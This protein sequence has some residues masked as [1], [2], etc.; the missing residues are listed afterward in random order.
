MYLRSEWNPQTRQFEGTG[1]GLSIVREIVALHK[2]TI[3]VESKQNRGTEFR[4]RI[5]LDLSSAEDQ[6][7]PGKL[8]VQNSPSHE[9][10]PR[11]S[12]GPSFSEVS[13]EKRNREMVLVVE[14]N[15]DMREYVG[16]CLSVNYN[17]LFAS[18]RT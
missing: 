16:E 18:H 14:D 13:P 1:I 12:P 7:V 2:G 6:P 8:S 5:P 17:V 4:I 9:A 11:E 3:T 10:E 15:A